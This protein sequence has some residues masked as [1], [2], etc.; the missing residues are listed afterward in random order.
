M[1]VVNF[2]KFIINVH[3]LIAGFGDRLLSEV[4]K[5]APNDIKIRVSVYLS[6]SLDYTC[7][8]CKYC[9]GSLSTSKVYYFDTIYIICDPSARNKLHVGSLQVEKI[10]N[11]HNK[12]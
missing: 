8:S 7:I 10:S 6:L 4:K 11:M 2:I 12:G 3:V 9:P 5:L 1:I